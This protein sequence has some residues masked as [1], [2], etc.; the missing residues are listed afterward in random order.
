MSFL[1][2]CLTVDKVGI[3]SDFL[4]AYPIRK[5]CPAERTC[6]VVGLTSV[7]P[8]YLLVRSDTNQTFR[9][10]NHVTGHVTQ[11]HSSPISIHSGG[12]SL[13]REAVAKQERSA[14]PMPE[15]VILAGASRR[16]AALII[17][18]TLLSAILTVA[19]RGRIVNIWNSD[20][21]FSTSFHYWIVMVLILTGSTWLYFRLTGVVFSRSLGQRM[22]SL[23]IVAEDG[24]EMTSAMW[25]RRSR[26]KLLFLIPLFNIYHAAYEVQRIRQR[27]THQSNLDRNIGSIVVISNSLPPALRRHLR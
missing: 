12:F 3:Q 11:D 10:L 5:T 19:T 17:D 2:H 14:W 6:I 15:G 13:A 1:R 25:D 27:H 16:S 4:N 8:R 7:H 20:L 23:A 9:H 24:S 26:G 21:L 22:F 18:M